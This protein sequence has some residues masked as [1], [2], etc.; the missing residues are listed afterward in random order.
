MEVKHTTANDWQALIAKLPVTV[1]VNR[2]S[3]DFCGNA[4]A[5]SLPYQ[6][7]EVHYGWLNGDIDN[8]VDAPWFTVLFDDEDVSEQYGYQVN[9]GVMTCPLSEISALQGS[10]DVLI[11]KDDSVS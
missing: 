5:L 8:A 4:S 7:D 2:Y 11:E 9:I 6:E 3:H 10:Y 1:Q